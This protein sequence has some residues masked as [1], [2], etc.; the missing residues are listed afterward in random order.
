MQHCTHAE[1]GQL[2]DLSYSCTENSFSNAVILRLYFCTEKS[3]VVQ[4]MNSKSILHVIL[5]VSTVSFCFSVFLSIY[6]TIK[7]VHFTKLLQEHKRAGCI[8]I[9]ITILVMYSL[10]F[11][12]HQSKPCCMAKL[13]SDP[14]KL[15]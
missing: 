8:N 10:T 1:C 14:Q 3:F 11:P 2:G 9:I 13:C 6:L 15:I 12:V 7:C 4:T 5:Q